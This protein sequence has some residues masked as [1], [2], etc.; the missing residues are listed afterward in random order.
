MA[1]RKE[2]KKIQ[3]EKKIIIIIIEQFE[4]TKVRFAQRSVIFTESFFYCRRLR[5][6]VSSVVNIVKVTNG[7]GPF[8]A[9][10]P[11]QNPN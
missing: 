11:T 6:I 10:K 1:H 4:G 7:V 2:K 9:Y 3:A 8:S 5:K